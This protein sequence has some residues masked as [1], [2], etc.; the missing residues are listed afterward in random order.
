MAH[1]MQEGMPPPQHILPPGMRKFV[2]NLFLSLRASPLIFGYF[3]SFA[4]SHSHSSLSAS[5]STNDTSSDDG[6]NRT[7]YSSTR[8]SSNVAPTKREPHSTSYGSDTYN[9]TSVYA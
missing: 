3:T 6:P 5:C 2:G 7:F 1:P 9:E 4:F 8:G